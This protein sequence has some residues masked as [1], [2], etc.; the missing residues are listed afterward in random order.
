MVFFSPSLSP[1][2]MFFG[3]QETLSCVFILVYYSE[4]VSEVFLLCVEMSAG[5]GVPGVKWELKS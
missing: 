3:G 5:H 2:I 1:S 4:S